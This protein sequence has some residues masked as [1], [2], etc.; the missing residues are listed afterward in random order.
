MY[1]LLILQV[2]ITLLPEYVFENKKGLFSG[3]GVTIWHS[4]VHSFMGFLG[5]VRN[6]LSVVAYVVE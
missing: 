6:S 4:L 5:G 1:F 3:L 2:L